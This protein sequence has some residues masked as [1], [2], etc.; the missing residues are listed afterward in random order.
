MRVLQFVRANLIT[1]LTIVGVFSGLA[2]GIIL[3]HVKHQW[4]EREV[5]YVEF[6]GELFLRMLKVLIIP[7]LTASIICAIGTL[8]LSLSKKIA[9][10]AIAYY[11]LTTIMAVSLGIILVVTIQPGL[12]VKNK[13]FSKTLP[14][15]RKVL[16]QDTLL[17]LIRNLF[18]PNLVQATM[19]QYSTKLE[20][21]SHPYFKEHDL[22]TW[23]PVEHYADNTNVLGLVF[24]SVIL[25]IAIG[26]MKEK[27]KP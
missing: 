13:E 7:L 14:E 24:F 11:G 27:A 3:K 16:T 9:L 8:D 2:V 18:P 20:N 4:T 23:T 15:V 21:N 5:K 1:I 10:R 26:I 12:H 6:P 17:D 19:Q 25:G 22:T